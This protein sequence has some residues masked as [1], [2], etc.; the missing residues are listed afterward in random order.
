MNVR[1]ISISSLKVE[2]FSR[3][4]NQ[5]E[6]KSD[7]QLA[8]TLQSRWKLYWRS[9]FLTTFTWSSIK[10]PRHVQFSHLALSS[11]ISQ[12]LFAVCQSLTLFG[13][14][15]VETL[16]EKEK[17]RGS[18]GEA[19]RR[20]KNRAP[21]GN[22]TWS[23]PNYFSLVFVF[24]W[25]FATALSRAET[26]CKKMQM[27]AS[28]GRDVVQR[29]PEIAVI[30]SSL[31][32]LKLNCAKVFLS[33]KSLITSFATLCECATTFTGSREQEKFWCNT[34]TRS[35]TNR[36]VETHKIQFNKLT[37]S[38]WRWTWLIK[39]WTIFK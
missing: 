5:T 27:Q 38:A 14:I 2:I 10:L 32:K 19:K 12:F 26:N 13:G 25:N 20:H 37:A 34:E 3:L 17:I 7:K 18:E 28:S 36:T 6:H 1:E 9:L 8:W 4:I 35:A 15:S 39:C 16:I 11:A 31:I 23:V 33:V 22:T 24:C 29:E 30:K 21:S